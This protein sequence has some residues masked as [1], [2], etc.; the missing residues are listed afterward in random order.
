MKIV[1][2]YSGGLDSMIMLHMAKRLHPEAE[3]KCIYYA[4]GAESEAQEISMLPEHVEVRK[5]DW[6]GETIKPVSKKDDPF[7]GPIY[8]PGRNLVF[9]VLAACQELPSQ[10][11]MGTLYDECNEKATDKNETFRHMTSAACSYALSPFIS[12]VVVKYP[13]VDRGWTKV[14]AVRYALSSGLTAKE[15]LSTVSCWHHDGTAPCGKCKQCFKRA[16]VFKLNGLSEPHKQDP[17][18]SEYGLDLARSYKKAVADGSQNLDE[19]N[20]VNMINSCY[21]LGLLPHY[22]KTLMVEE[23]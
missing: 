20:V 16:L 4:H 17:I 5:V 21:K 22:Y 18:D 7:A 8:I 9:S 11:W 1:I 13:F 10:I 14:D 12:G 19:N 2:L 15:I 3:I 23:E 6:L